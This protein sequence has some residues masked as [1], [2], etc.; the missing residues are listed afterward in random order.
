MS[1]ERTNGELADAIITPHCGEG[2]DAC[3]APSRC[4]LGWNRCDDLI[5][6]IVAL[7]ELARRANE[8]TVLDVVIAQAAATP[9]Q[10]QP[11]EANVYPTDDTWTIHLWHDGTSHDIR[12]PRRGRS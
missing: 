10:G 2:C 12:L 8:A 5:R 1:D 6:P 7:G 11:I 4:P 3:P 9:W